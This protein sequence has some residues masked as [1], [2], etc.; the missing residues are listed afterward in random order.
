MTTPRQYQPAWEQLKKSPKSELKIAAHPSVHKRIY[1]AIC[2][3]K[4]DDLVYKMMLDERGKTAR[5][6]HTS[7]V[8]RGF[9]VIKLIETLGLDDLL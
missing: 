6:T 7:D 4:N 1:K 9:L 2:K 8:K 5:L 3:E